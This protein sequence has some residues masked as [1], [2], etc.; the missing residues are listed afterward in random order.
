MDVLFVL[1]TLALVL[2]LFGLIVSIDRLK[3]K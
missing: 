3:R 1:V 2:G